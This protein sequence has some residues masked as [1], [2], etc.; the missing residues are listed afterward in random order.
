MIIDQAYAAIVPM[1]A[2]FTG[3][4]VK[5]DFQ[6]IFFPSADLA[7]GFSAGA[8]NY[9]TSCFIMPKIIQDKH[10]LFTLRISHGGSD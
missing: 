7:R 6:F 9:S 2:R 10:A 1:I 8:F 5:I 4:R 3:C